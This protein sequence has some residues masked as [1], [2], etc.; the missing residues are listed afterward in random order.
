M[1]NTS[2]ISM[3]KLSKRTLR[4]SAIGIGICV[5]VLFI[6]SQEVRGAGVLDSVSKVVEWTG[7]VFLPLFGLNLDL[8][9]ERTAKVAGVGMVGVH[10]VLM[11]LVYGSLP[12]LTYITI[13]PLAVIEMFVL[14][15]PFLRIRKRLDPGDR[16]SRR[17]WPPSL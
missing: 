12:S 9:P 16:P 15:I 11:M 1:Q 4:N 13:T 8:Y 7:M 10:V 17:R 2:G 3:E 6:V 14:V 5:V